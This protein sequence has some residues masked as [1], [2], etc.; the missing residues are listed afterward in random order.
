MI[1]TCLGSA[2]A[3]A[4]R[5]GVTILQ[6]RQKKILLRQGFPCMKSDWAYYSICWFDEQTDLKKRLIL[7]ALLRDPWR[8]GPVKTVKIPRAWGE[9]SCGLPTGSRAGL[10]RCA[11]LYRFNRL[12][13]V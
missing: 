3:L 13:W 2:H 8:G 11:D 9:F 1:H 7:P 6:P 4:R 5:S 10:W 12:D